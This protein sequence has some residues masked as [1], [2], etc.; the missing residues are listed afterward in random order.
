MDR[1]DYIQAI[2]SHGGRLADAVE[3]AGLAAPVPSCPGWTNLDLVRHASVVC[4]FW[5]ALASGAVT[6]PATFVPPAQPSEGD[7]IDAFRADVSTIAATLAPLDP[8]AACWTWSDAQDIGFVQRRLAQELAVHGWDATVAAG[9]PEP[10]EPPL[11]VDG[12]D[13]YLDVFVPH[14]AGHADGTPLRAHLH[15]TDADGEWVMDLGDG[16]WEVERTHAKGDVAIRGTASDLLL[17][18][19]GRRPLADGDFEVFGEPDVVDDL[20]GRIAMS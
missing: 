7:T 6:D 13:E 8:A 20:L 11:A 4:E 1:D 16:R 19:W 12:I 17:L 5:Q 15:T 3:T 2:R 18:L 10:I 14:R 9:R